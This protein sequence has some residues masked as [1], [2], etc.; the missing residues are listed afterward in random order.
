M[1]ITTWR[2]KKS[3]GLYHIYDKAI[4]CTNERDGLKVIIYHQKSDYVR[5]FV[6]EESEFYEKFEKVPQLDGYRWDDAQRAIL[7]L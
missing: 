4:D 3:G 1:K 2:N 6:R 5:V 7:C